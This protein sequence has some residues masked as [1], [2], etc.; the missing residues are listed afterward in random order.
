MQASASLLGRGEIGA[1][2]V[3]GQAMGPTLTVSG[4]RS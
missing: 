2:T 3:Y 4:G 1:S